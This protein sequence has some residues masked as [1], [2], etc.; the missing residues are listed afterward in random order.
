MLYH[1]EVNWEKRFDYA[2]N[3][4]IKRDMELTEHL[5]QHLTTKDKPKYDID[6]NKLISICKNVYAHKQPHLYVFEIETD[7][8]TGMIIK[9]CF[10]TDYDYKRDISIVVK[11]GLIIT[12]WLNNYHD[13]HV[14]LNK[15][16]YLKNN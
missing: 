11:D 7:D 3:Y 9:A 16:K 14:S 10:R 1:K 6:Y 8:N 2:L 15:E 13:K 5:W 12:A 4:L